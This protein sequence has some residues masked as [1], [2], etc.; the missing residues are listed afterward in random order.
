[1]PTL[2]WIGKD[3][4]EHHHAEVPYRLV[5]CDGEFSP[6]IQTRATFWFRATIS[7]P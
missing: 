3:A 1:M 2:K 7:K 5:H 4:V 6:V